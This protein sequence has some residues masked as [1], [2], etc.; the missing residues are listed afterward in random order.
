[1][2]WPLYPKNARVLHLANY[3]NV[4]IWTLEPRILQTALVCKNIGVTIVTSWALIFLCHKV[5]EMHFANCTFLPVH[6]RPRAIGKCKAS[7]KSWKWCTSSSNLLQC[8]YVFK[9]LIPAA[10]SSPT[11]ER[12]VTIKPSSA[13]CFFTISLPSSL[14][15]TLMSSLVSP[16]SSISDI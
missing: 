7:D 1:M 3:Y 6:C 9:A 11:A 16:P 14:S 4:L 13:S 5:R 12:M 2:F 8:H 15:G 10:A